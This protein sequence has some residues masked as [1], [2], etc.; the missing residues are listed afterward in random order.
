M[1][2][3]IESKERF[4]SQLR[5]PEVFDFIRTSGLADPPDE[6]EIESALF[7]LCEWGNLQADADTTAVSAVEDFYSQRHAYQMTSQGEAAE[8]ALAGFSAT[9]GRES[10][11][12][13]SG[14]A[15]IR[16]LLQELKQLSGLAELDADKIHRNLLVLRALFEDLSKTAQNFIARLEPRIDLQPSEARRL[17]D[18]GQQFIE[19]LVL[20]ADNI[21]GVIHDIEAAGLERL[22]QALAKRG[23]PQGM[24]A[25]EAAG[26]DVYSQWRLD[27]DRF[28][29]WFVS[30]PGFP[31]HSD[32]LRERARESVSALLSII[33]RANDQRNF[34]I[35]RANDFRVLAR[36]F[37]QAGSDVEAHLLWRAAFGLCPA[38]HLLINDATLDDRDAHDVPPNTSWL[39]APPLR[40]SVWLRDYC[41]NSGTGGLSRIIDRS[42]E[43]E[44]LAAATQEEAQRLLHAQHRFDTGDRI[45]LSELEHLETG[46]F[47]LFLDLLGEAVSARVFAEEPVEIL[48][49][50]GCLRVK[51]EPTGDGREAMILTADGVLSGPDHWIS[52]EQISANHAE[53]VSI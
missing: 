21:A 51:L 5:P 18:Y 2:A 35:D 39:D 36:W 15:D 29:I 33:A 42:A 45:R 28:R 17:V 16:L 40:L 52:V 7:Q 8:R 26:A 31:S 19:E 44:K 30:Q 22:L 13:C 53:G 46:E 50:D 41:R 12:C 37:A 24:N 3:F 9:S 32:R 49:G 48:S 14:L 4:I 1:R 20:E 38:R 10:A 27:W 25:G 47:E 43:K 11:L 23:I 34:R 6:T